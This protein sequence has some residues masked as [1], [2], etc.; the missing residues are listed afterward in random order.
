MT[1]AARS[2]VL[3]G[4]CRARSPSPDPS[5]PAGR[6]PNQ[7]MKNP[8]GVCV[9]SAPAI[10][11]MMPRAASRPATP[12]INANG[13]M[14]SVTIARAASGA[15]KPRLLVIQPSVPLNP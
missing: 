6:L 11:P 13:A 10:R 15:G 3:R 14:S 1:P 7:F 5:A 2:G 9:V 8:L 12:T 4:P